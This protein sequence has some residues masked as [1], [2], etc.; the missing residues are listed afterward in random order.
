MCSRCIKGAHTCEYIKSPPPTIEFVE[1]SG[2]KSR[3]NA[4]LATSSETW[5]SVIE[6]QV[7]LVNQAKLEDGLIQKTPFWALT[8]KGEAAAIANEWQGMQV[9]K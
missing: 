8:E 7:A 9:H 2:L 4:Q 3:A 6:S 1:P 5:K